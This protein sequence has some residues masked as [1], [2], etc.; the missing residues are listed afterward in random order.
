MDTIDAYRR[1]TD[2]AVRIMTTVAPDQM[3]LPTPCTE[4]AVQN[5]IDHM[6]GSTGYLRAALAG[7]PPL[8]SIASTVNDFIEGR[9]AVVAG[10]AEPGA[11]E[12]MC[13]S[14]LGFEWTI[15]DAVMGTIMDTLVHTWD[16]AT[17]TGQ[18]ASL[19][20]ELVALCIDLF[21]PEMA[22]RGREGGLVGPAITVANDAPADVRLLAAMGRRT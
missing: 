10:L 20:P 3:L 21:L 22:E 2:G 18:S 12:R 1:A 13:L 15:L 9:T 19:D 16:L 5:L 6:T 8:P 7:E 14:P 17:A 4:W 11:L